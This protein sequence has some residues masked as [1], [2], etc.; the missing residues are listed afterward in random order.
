MMAFLI[1]LLVLTVKNPSAA[2]QRIAAMN[3]S[4]EDGWSALALGAILNTFLYYLNLA[5]FPVPPDFPIPVIQGPFIFLTLALSFNVILVFGLFWCGKI[6]GGTGQLTTLVSVIAWLMLALVAGDIL[7]VLLLFLMP[8]FSSLISLGIKLYAIWVLLN[9][10]KVAH[11]LP[12]IGASVFT[13]ALTVVGMIM[14]MS[15]FLS[16]MGVTAIGIN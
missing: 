10:I 12:S 9:F 8:L 4:R 1:D 3:L 7:S 16:F 14:G 13:L 11:G 15:V 6:V 5:L 2:A